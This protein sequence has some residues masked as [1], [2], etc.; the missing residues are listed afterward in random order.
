VRSPTVED[1]PVGDGIITVLRGVVLRAGQAAPDFGGEL[2]LLI[3]ITG[4]PVS[5]CWRGDES[6]EAGGIGIDRREQ[7]G[8]A[9][10]RYLCAY[11]DEDIGAADPFAV[12]TVAVLRPIRP[13]VSAQQEPGQHRVVGRGR[14]VEAQQAQ[15]VSLRTGEI[16]ET[17][18]GGGPLVDVRR[19]DPVP[20]AGAEI[21]VVRQQPGHWTAAVDPA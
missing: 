2:S 15:V 13:E 8:C 17:G 7:P 9:E 1:H 19:T 5:P 14:A 10:R 12:N 4:R 6:C 18:Q 20:V 16:V 21:A 11:R 3:G